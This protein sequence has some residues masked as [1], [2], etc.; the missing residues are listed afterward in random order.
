MRRPQVVDDEEHERVHERVAAIDVAKDS[1]MVCTRTP[2]PSRAGARRS[3]PGPA[4]MAP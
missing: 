1:G 2:H 3:A 4:I